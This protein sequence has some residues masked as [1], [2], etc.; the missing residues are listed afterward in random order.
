MNNTCALRVLHITLSNIVSLFVVLRIKGTFAIA[1]ALASNKM[2]TSIHKHYTVEE[3]NQY[4]NTHK[5][6]LP[7]VAVSTGTSAD[8]KAKLGQILDTVDCNTICIDVA[9]G[10]SEH[11]VNYVRSTREQFPKHN[12]IAGNVV[13]GEMVEELILSGADAVKVV[14]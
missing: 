12:I 8:D 13:T 7:Y 2:L 4:A 11:F 3:W 6:S 10:Y 1:N 14:C 9:N 5:S